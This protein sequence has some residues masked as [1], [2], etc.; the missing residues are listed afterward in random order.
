VQNRTHYLCVSASWRL[1]VKFFQ[2]GKWL[3]EEGSNFRLIGG[4]LFGSLKVSAVT[5]AEAFGS[6]GGKP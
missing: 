4:R 5:S 3:K 6:S 2:E 1:C